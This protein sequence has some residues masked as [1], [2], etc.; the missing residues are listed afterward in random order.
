[1]TTFNEMVLAVSGQLAGYTRS[2]DQSTHLTQAVAA[3]DTQFTVADPARI[4]R[5]I[6]EVDDELLWVDSFDAQNLTVTVPPYGRG[7]NGT[8]AASHSSGARATLNPPYPRVRIKKAI[9][10]TIQAV[11][12]DLYAVRSDEFTYNA[13]QVTYDAPA[14]LS[15]ILSIWWETFSSTQYWMPVT[16]WKYNHSASAAFTTGKSLD[17]Y[18]PIMPGRTVRVVY[19]ADP[20]ALSADS[21]VFTTT[22]GLEA[23]HEDV[24]VYGAL[25]RLTAAAEAQRLDQTALEADMLDE[26]NPIGSAQALSRYYFALH[27]QRLDEERRKLLDKHPVTVHYA[28]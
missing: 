10:D 22:T 18:D 17:L 25:A 6:V 28:R 16:R 7:F 9:N 14:D 8:T 3:G 13:S 23:S 5:G 21:D 15:N 26:P 4:G 24:I 2:H 12:G 20:A 11:A 19:A 27:R 1:V